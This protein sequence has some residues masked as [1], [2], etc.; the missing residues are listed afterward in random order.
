[1]GSSNTNS[2]QVSLEI[3]GSRAQVTFET[4]EGLN[5][6][7]TDTLRTFGAVV[8]RLKNEPTLRTTTIRAAGKVFMAG[9]DVK[10]I[11]RFNTEAA[12]EYATVGQGIMADLAALPC[13]TVAAIHGVVL[14]A[15]LE[16]AL[17][18]DFRIAVK[19]AKLGLPEVSLGLIPPW[20]GI[21]RLM[22]L[23]GSSRAKRL[24]L[25]PTSVS[26]E[27]GIH[28]GLIDEVVN[29]AEDLNTRLPKF[30]EGFYRASPGAV[31]G[32]KRA[33]RN[34]DDLEAFLECF[35]GRQARE[36]MAAFIEKRPARWME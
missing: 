30:C 3:A 15:G 20:G 10:E 27:Q 31:A 35:D 14:G 5:V 12:R 16:I 28:W 17:A 4:K 18:C 32:I 24:L 25:D 22:K 8:A 34:F 23:V 19:T 1:M 33:S 21:N 36:G 26:A 11:A 7:S 9:S 13:I 2:T 29:S 6:L